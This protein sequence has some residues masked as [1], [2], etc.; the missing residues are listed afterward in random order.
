MGRNRRHRR[1]DAGPGGRGDA[2]AARGRRR[3]VVR[4]AYSR[5]WTTAGVEFCNGLSGG[6]DASSFATQC[7]QSG[8]SIVASCPTANALGCCT[9]AE[10]NG[11]IASSCTY[12]PKVGTQSEVETACTMSSGTFT[13]GLVK[14]CGDASSGSSSGSSG[15][16]GG[17][18]GDHAMPGACMQT[19]SS[20][21]LDNEMGCDPCIQANCPTEYAACQ[22]DNESGSCINCPQLLQGADSGVECT[23][24]PTIVANLL[25]C[26][27][28]STTCK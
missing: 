1:H 24:T 11:T 6:G 17:E 16:A 25:D 23:N 8:G 7:T 2:A 10:G 21:A 27:C 22:N 4:Q 14:S 26:A 20:N 19:C 3:C 9:I 28:Q 13:A 18:G 12:C 15:D 5:T